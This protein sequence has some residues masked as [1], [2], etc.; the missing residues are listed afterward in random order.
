MFAFALPTNAAGMDNMDMSDHSTMNMGAAGNGMNEDVN[1][2]MIALFIAII[3]I[4]GYYASKTE[5]SG[6]LISELHITA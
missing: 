2:Y 1:R 6:K 3:G 4:A 5:N